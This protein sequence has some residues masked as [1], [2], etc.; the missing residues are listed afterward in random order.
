MIAGLRPWLA[1]AGTGQAQL[2]LPQLMPGAEIWL[3]ED[4]KWKLHRSAARHGS[5]PQWHCADV[6]PAAGCGAPGARMLLAVC[7][8]AAG[9]QT[10]QGPRATARHPSEDEQE[11]PHL[12]GKKKA[13]FSVS[14]EYIGQAFAQGPPDMSH[15]PHSSGAGA[16][17]ADTRSLSPCDS[18]WG[19]RVLCH[20]APLHE[21]Q[22]SPAPPAW[23][24]HSRPPPTTGQQLG[25]QVA[26]VGRQ[27][28][29][30][31]KL[32]VRNLLARDE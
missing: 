1:G 8:N 15:L 11:L 16:V 31:C 23:D 7:T 4:G 10:A 25:V 19:G 18:A 29:P 14:M 6:L 22:T 12:P 26:A 2:P 5:V 27:Q 17:P 3:Q 21:S 30:T 32:H 20:H 24:W 9:S 28:V 13:Y